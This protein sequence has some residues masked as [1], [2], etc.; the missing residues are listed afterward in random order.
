MKVLFV[1]P[2]ISQEERYGRLKDVGTIYPSL[3]TGYVAAIAE[4]NECEVKI[5]DSEAM[6]YDYDDIKKIIE[7]FKPDMIGMQ[8]Y[9]TN[10][11]KCYKIAKIAKNFDK[12]I[13][14]ILGGAHATLSPEDS[15]QNENIDFIIYGEGEIVFTNLL[16]A[17][18]KKKSFENINGLVWKDK[19]KVIKNGP[20][21]LIQNLNKL[22]F[23]A[24]HLFSI[25]RYHASANLRGKRTL[26]II[27]SRGCPFRCAYCSGHRTFGETHRYNSA[28]KVIEEINLLISKYK[29]DSI[30]FYDE[31]FTANRKRVMELCGALIEDNK[32]RKKKIEWSCFTRVNLVDEELLEK[33]KEAGC[34][35]IYYGFESGV[36]RLLDLI[37]KDITL[38]QQK[39]AVELTHKAGIE[40]WGSFMLALPT[41]TI[42]DSWKTIN[43][44]IKLNIDSILFPI[45]RPFPGTELYDLCKSN[46][47]ILTED[48]TKF[49]SWDEVIY[50]PEGRSVEEIK[51]TAKQAYRKFYLRPRF[52]LK[53]AWRLLRKLPLKNQYNLIKTG[54]SLFE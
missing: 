38:E 53:K 48:W 2:P 3:G 40:V 34:Y 12:N 43:W 8:T 22:P 36:Q 13:K 14:I 19:G 39:R 33:M 1:Y 51:E 31:I 50:L 27:T 45:T 17:L 54:L 52:I 26:N 11:S 30:Q 21:E 49:L 25:E 29:V 35:L 42:E 32:K 20:Q 10:L 9:C 46:G 23:P 16:N 4:K 28:E 6:N 44:A 37:K 41:E 15:I 24:R 5:V 18:I 7:E 47:K